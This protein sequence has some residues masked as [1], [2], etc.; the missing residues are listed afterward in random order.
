MQRFL[1]T[2]S[3]KRQHGQEEPKR[4]VWDLFDLQDLRSRSLFLS[5]AFYENKRAEPCFVLT[6]RRKMHI[7]QHLAFGLFI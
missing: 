4:Y 7:S 5:G 1:D 2:S 6:F 3:V